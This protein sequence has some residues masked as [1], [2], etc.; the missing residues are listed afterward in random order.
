MVEIPNARL[1]FPGILTAGQPSPEQLREIR[2]RGFKTVINLRPQ[3]ELGDRDEAAEA[4]ALGLRYRLIPIDGAQGVSQESAALLVE[5]LEDP[6]NYPVLVHCASSN[7]VGALF[8]ID[9]GIRRGQ[10]L[11]EALQTGRSAGMQSLET[12]VRE[13]LLAK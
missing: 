11:D 10:G 2:E 9:A 8:A 12:R 1:P 3:K 5:A 6:A 4:A 7:R 13:L